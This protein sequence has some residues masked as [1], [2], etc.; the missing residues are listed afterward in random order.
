[1]FFPH[2]NDIAPDL[3]GLGPEYFL[4]DPRRP[5]DKHAVA[6]VRVA[7][8]MF[9]LAG[10]ACR[11]LMRARGASR[12]WFL[13]CCGE[14]QAPSCCRWFLDHF[15]HGSPTITSGPVPIP[16]PQQQEG[17]GE[18][19]RQGWGKECMAV[20]TGLCRGGHLDSARRSI[21]GTCDSP[22]ATA[23]SSGG[24][25]RFVFYPLPTCCHEYDNDD[26]CVAG[27]GGDYTVGRLES[28]F[29]GDKGIP[30]LLDIVAE[31][32]HL[33]TLKWALSRFG[34]TEESWFLLKRLLS[35]AQGFQ[36]D[37]VVWLANAINSPERLGPQLK[38]WWWGVPQ[39]ASDI[40]R[41]METLFPEWPLDPSNM[42]WSAV[43][44]KGPADEIISV[45][46]W[47]TQWLPSEEMD[48]TDSRNCEVV[49]WALE[50]VNHS[51]LE[52]KLGRILQN[53]DDVQFA[54]WLLER[55]TPTKSDFQSVCTHRKDNVDIA[56]LVCEN[57]PLSSEDILDALHIALANGNTRIAQFLEECFF[58]LT[59]TTSTLSL[60]K[61]IEYNNIDGPAFNWQHAGVVNI[62]ES[63]V[64]CVLKGILDSGSTGSDLALFLIEK[65][66]PR[67]GAWF[68]AHNFLKEAMGNGGDLLQVKRI[69]KVA[70]R[71]VGG[72]AP[73]EI[74]S[75]LENYSNSSKVVKWLISHFNLGKHM[76]SKQKGKILVGLISAN[77][78]SCAQ[79]FSYKFSVTTE[80]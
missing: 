80:D 32:G 47:L 28:E 42:A 54:Q 78:C 15:P 2:R 61:L 16:S 30:A 9:P 33:D 77:K 39:S 4:L 67:L 35:A 48:F 12:R 70:E 10:P 29:W 26:G 51:L 25:S 34:G 20:L 5:K 23:T 62:P 49:K 69:V 21:V 58:N 7:E 57:L 73:T 17:Q 22:R 68:S 43:N 50:C 8:A 19:R 56:K 13:R 45:C 66:R 14:A 27:S 79:W 38:N 6:L 74:L 37:T 63:E 44:C 40:R 18:W 71:Q 31:R 24:G 55:P 65:F 1:M 52:P 72:L 46:T 3:E 64:V 41:L 76:T 36:V 59:K 60:S 75:L 53:V 11:A